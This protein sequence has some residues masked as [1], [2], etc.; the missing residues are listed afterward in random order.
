L[1]AREITQ[2]VDRPKPGRRGPSQDPSLAREFQL[3]K[4]TSFLMAMILLAGVVVVAFVSLLAAGKLLVPQAPTGVE[5]IEIAAEE[6]AIVE[7]QPLAAAAGIGPAE[8]DDLRTATSVLDLLA[9]TASN[10]DLLLIEAE[11]DEPGT[12]GAGSG[13]GQ[14]GSKEGSGVVPREQRWSIVHT[15]GESAQEYAR[16]LDHFGIELA[17][18]LDFNQ[19]L[20]V[21]KLASAKP[22]KRIGS[23]RQERRLY[24]TWRG[25]GRRGADLALL[26]KAD[27]RVQRG[28][29]VQF[30]PAEVEAAL[31]ALEK[32]YGNRDPKEISRT[33]F[34]IRK[35]SSG[36]AFFVTIQE[37]RK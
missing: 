20:Y 11:E 19:L 21:S 3:Q 16:K 33:L 9:E 37:Y 2:K 24:W 10:P 1:K 34:G 25:E 15:P 14:Q 4:V 22:A 32:S 29:I 27:I 13:A 17:V 5:F 12:G 30:V 28:V 8:A 26:R 18:A 6:G 7:N 36:Y 35:T 31:A 23:G